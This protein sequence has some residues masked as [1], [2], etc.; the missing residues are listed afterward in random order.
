M[1]YNSS[2]IISGIATIKTQPRQL[3]VKINFNGE[4][5]IKLF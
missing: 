5:E 1:C 4:I 2:I 3:F